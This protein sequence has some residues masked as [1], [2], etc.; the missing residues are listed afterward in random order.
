MSANTSGPDRIPGTNP[1]APHPDPPQDPAAFWEAHYGDK[2]VWSGN[3]NAAL[4]DASAHLI[5]G[6]VLDLGCG[7]GGDVI[8]LAQQGWKAVGVDISQAAIIRARA[9]AEAADLS[10]DR[11]E[12]VLAD[13]TTLGDRSRHESLA[14]PFELVTASFFQSPVALD[15]QRILQAAAELVAPGGHL[16]LTS[17]AAPPP[18]ANDQAS[19]TDEH[20]G[21]P[22]TGPSH[23]P[24]PE[25]EL[26]TL[27]LDTHDWETLTAGI[28]TRE[29]TAPD[30]A[31]GHLD[32]TVVLVR[33][34][35]IPAADVR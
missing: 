18:W 9:A 21:G 17:H 11:A 29:A 26:A 14:G 19:H 7:E 23:F 5:P 1:Q 32:D 30:G 24:S 31:H 33:R 34:R 13:L 8:W 22:T 35:G 15:R 2:Q 16:L 20:A 12:F 27:A 6:R 25:E 28:R 3:V 4:A 10:P